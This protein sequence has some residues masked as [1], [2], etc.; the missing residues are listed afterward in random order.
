MN[1]ACI[2][3]APKSYVS[4]LKTAYT[5]LSG[6]VTAF[7]SCTEGLVRPE[8]SVG[9]HGYAQQMLVCCCC[10]SWG[11][12][13]ICDPCLVN[14][15]PAAPATH[16][17]GVL[18]T[19]PFAHEATARQ[20][21]HLF[22]YQG[23]GAAGSVLAKAMAP[24]LPNNATAL[25]PVPRAMV[26]KARYGIDPALVLARLISADTGV[27]VIRALAARVWWPAHA[28][29]SRSR[30]RPPQFAAVLEAPPGSVLVDD[31]LTTGATI[32]AAGSI[33]GLRQALTATRA[34]T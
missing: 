30:R 21:V 8:V 16:V 10:Q 4:F 27:P 1:P 17:S 11:C 20:L 31:V 23:V 33:T 9:G 34:G 6:R 14:L 5:T 19:A 2:F 24:L 25:V 18:V 22:K 13:P 29:T 28:G 3:L 32:G 12:G 26:R 15:V 7:R